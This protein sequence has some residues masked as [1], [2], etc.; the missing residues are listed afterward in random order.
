M[1]MELVILTGMSGAG[2]SMAANYLEDMGYFCIDNI[3]P[4]LLPVLVRAFHKGA[5][6]ETPTVIG[7]SRLA[8]VV[9]VRSADLL[10]GFRPAV[11]KIKEMGVPHRIIYLEATDKVL[12]SRY[13]QSRR[14]HP[15]AQGG[16]IAKAMQMERDL[17]API[18]DMASAVIDTSDFKPGELRDRLYEL[19]SENILEN[20]MTILIQ[21]FG[22]KYGIPLDSDLVIDVR[23]VPNPYYIAELKTLSGLDEPVK[24]Y[25]FSFEEGKSFMD[26]Q[27][28]AIRYA[29]PYYVRE[30]KVRLTIA[31]GCTGG[32]H[33]SVAMAEDLA[34]RLQDTGYRTI[35]DH[36]D[37]NKDPSQNQTFT[38]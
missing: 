29:L 23:F 18:K 15:L 24:D 17:L 14:N 19:L 36:R 10:Q 9:D 13:K 33:R 20:R 22:F 12:L 31:I 5:N 28:Q 1:E 2:K 25:V 7:I 11:E 6:A 26:L 32:R 4:Q 16:S 34:A 8:I 21:S 30:G 27:E 37:I 3:P 38:L 35:V